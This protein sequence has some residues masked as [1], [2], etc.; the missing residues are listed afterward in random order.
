MTNFTVELPNGNDF[1][2]QKDLTESQAAGVLVLVITSSISALSILI[3][4]AALAI[5]AWNTRKVDNPNLFV[6]SHAVAYLVSLL[7]CDLLQAIGSIMNAEWYI[8]RAV[9]F[10]PFCEAQGAIK[11]IA[12]LGTAIWSLVI[13]L[14]T[15]WV[16]FLRIQTRKLVMIASLVAVWAGIATL[17]ISGPAALP[18]KRDGPFFAISGY[19]CWISDQYTVSRI[20]LDYMFMFISAALSFILYILIFMKLR[21][22]I[23]VVGTRVRF[24]M[25]RGT[26]AVTGL[27]A[28]D[29]IVAIAKT[30][31]IYPVAYTIIIAPIAIVRFMEMGGHDVSFFAT[32]F[33]D[34]IYLCS[35][36]HFGS[37]RLCALA[38]KSIGTVNV[39][40]FFLTR[41]VLP[42]H[43]VITKKFTPD[44]STASQFSFISED[45]LR[46]SKPLDTESIVGLTTE[47]NDMF[48]CVDSP[49]SY[50]GQQ[51]DDL[52]HSFNPSFPIPAYAEYSRYSAASLEHPTREMLS[53]LDPQRTL[54]SYG[55]GVPRHEDHFQTTSAQEHRRDVDEDPS[56]S[57]HSEFSD[58]EREADARSDYYD[59]VD[60]YSGPSRPPSSYN[61]SPPPSLPPLPPPPTSFHP[62]NLTRNHTP[63]PTNGR[64]SFT[65]ERNS[66]LTPVSG[67]S[68]R[69]EYPAS[70]ASPMRYPQSPL[71]K[72]FVRS[73]SVPR[74]V[75][76]SVGASNGSGSPRS[77]DLRGF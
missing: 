68:P 9:T 44:P 52:D 2:L 25:R 54:P 66:S 74:V 62:L 45:V 33:T 3:L 10:L 12:D 51:Q 14:H 6:R 1:W 27:A 48:Q 46:K 67:S 39:L 59:V 70:A 34:T 30:M 19:W 40:L 58:R 35:G 71:T 56:S 60:D 53:A 32:I 64:F 49:D 69:M 50:P 29:E 43:S 24:R 65:Q 73:V 8:D 38:D 61:H 7:L 5:S 23:V 63:S 26:D 18:T 57:D 42:R 4:F 21:G 55:S 72:E 31:L 77:S 20:T 22:N 37:V 17:V 47:K 16:L 41:R 76:S 15:F 13:A 75:G 28:D 36:R 11:Q